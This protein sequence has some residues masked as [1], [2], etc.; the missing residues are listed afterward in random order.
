MKEIHKNQGFFH[1][2]PQDV[3]EN[4]GFWLLGKQIGRPCVVEG[5]RLY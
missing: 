5:C 2:R 1:Q 3:G 4:C